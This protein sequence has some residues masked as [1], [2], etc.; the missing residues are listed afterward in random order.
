MSK[1]FRETVNNFKRDN[2][3]ASFSEK[4]M[5]MYIVSKVDRLEEV[6][7]ERFVK[8]NDMFTTKTTFWKIVGIITVIVGG[9]FSYFIAHIIG[10]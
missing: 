4:D 2:G 3:N 9:M 6:V 8:C 1:K 5:L 7:S 10:G